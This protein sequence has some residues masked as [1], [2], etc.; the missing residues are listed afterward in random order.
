MDK[1]PVLLVLLLAL[2]IVVAYVGFIASAPVVEQPSNVGTV[3]LEVVGAPASASSS[4]GTVSL[5]V[6]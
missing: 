4:A 1:K 3:Q 2:A 5:I 6:V